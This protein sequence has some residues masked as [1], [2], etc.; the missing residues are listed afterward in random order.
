M[1]DFSIKLPDYVFFGKNSMEKLKKQVGR[2]G[3]KTLIVTGKNSAIKSGALNDLIPILKEKDIKYR[4][5]DEIVS[6]PLN[7]I[8]DT[9]AVVSKEFGANFLIA[10]GGGSVMDA[11]KGI[12]VVHSNGGSIWDYVY[13]G[14]RSAKKIKKALSVIAI[15]TLAASGSELDGGAVITN[16]KTKEKIAFGSFHTIPKIAVLNPIYTFTTP[17]EYTAYGAADIISHLTESFL[18]TREENSKISDQLISS[19][20]RIV[21]NNLP[22]VLKKPDDY[23]SRAEIMLASSLALSGIPSVGTKG[24]F[25]MH[26]LEHP[27]SGH[28]NIPHGKGLA[29]LFIPYFKKMKVIN[30]KRVEKYF[31]LI[32]NSNIDEGIQK[33]E[34]W[35]K[36]NFLPL[37]LSEDGVNENNIKVFAEDCIR[38]SSSGKGYLGEFR[39]LD[40]DGIIEIYKQLID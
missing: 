2:F 17:K 6:N 25:I 34:I 5:F 18:G 16:Q 39:E 15:P 30:K 11:A 37:K 4:I 23:D 19:L 35:I 3:R 1:L 36:N 9:G 26:Y 32:F 27:M 28:L 29:A 40:R 24:N 21:I 8:I 20:I 13:D 12:A 38:I 31:E 33:F 10:I 22:E 14:R 7:T